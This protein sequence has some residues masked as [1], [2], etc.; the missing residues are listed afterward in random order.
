MY[1]SRQSQWILGVGFGLSLVLH[2]A[3]WLGLVSLPSSDDL[4]AML[5]FET[6]AII[7]EP[8]PPPPPPEPEPEVVEPEPEPEPEVP[9]PPVRRERPT[10]PTEEP[11]P[12]DDTPPPAAEEQIED[13]TGET[14]TNDS[15]D[16]WQSAVGSGAPM[17]SPIGGPTGVVTG[18]RREGSPD[19]VVGGS[20]TGAVDPGPRMVGLRDLSA[21]PSLPARDHLVELVRQYYPGDL[22]RQSIEGRATVRLR[23]GPDG[24]VSRVRMRNESHEGFGQACVRVI[25]EAGAWG[26]PLDR[27]GSPVATQ[28]DFECIFDLHL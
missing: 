27:D 25:Q 6:V 11:P 4:A 22:R 28:V 26:T 20:G 12:P 24:R 15:T 14:L 18:R 2:V 3:A 17:D 16:G 1:D 7:E 23:V 9:P 13:F 21:P 8:P 19:G 5:H 10:A